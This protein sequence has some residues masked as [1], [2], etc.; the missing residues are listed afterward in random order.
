MFA[1]GHLGCE[2]KLNRKVERC[3]KYKATT[4]C[5]VRLCDKLG[6]NEYNMEIPLKRRVLY[7]D[8]WLAPIET[9]R[10]GFKKQDWGTLYWSYQDGDKYFPIQ[11][12]RWTL[13]SMNRDDHIVLECRDHPPY[14]WAIGWH[15]VH[16][17]CYVTTNGTT[18]P[19]PSALKK[20]QDR[21]GKNY[22]INI[23][24]PAIIAKYQQAME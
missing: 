15:D 19:G 21:Y 20:R 18:L 16:Y 8:S 4:A 10:F 3:R 11:A 12:M 6:M 14:L 1:K 2:L 17:K 7:A 9:A 24:R 23:P 22:N 13:A 5:T